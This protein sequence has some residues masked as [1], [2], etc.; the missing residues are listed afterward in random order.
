MGSEGVR[1]G[2]VSPFDYDST[3]GFRL[4][5]YVPWRIIRVRMYIK[6]LILLS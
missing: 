1:P 4:G 2:V 5:R 6:R 3:D